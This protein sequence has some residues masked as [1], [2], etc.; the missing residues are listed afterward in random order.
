VTSS[1]ILNLETAK[2]KSSAGKDENGGDN[3]Q[4]D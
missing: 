4:E 1:H 2:A 3:K